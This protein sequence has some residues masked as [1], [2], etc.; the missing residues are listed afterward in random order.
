M[1]NYLFD[2]S[3]EA[4]DKWRIVFWVAL[5]IGSSMAALAIFMWVSERRQSRKSCKAHEP[6]V[7]PTESIPQRSEEVDKSYNQFLA[8]LKRSSGTPLGAPAPSKKKDAPVIT[9]SQA[10][11]ITVKSLDLST[12]EGINAAPSVD[13]IYDGELGFVLLNVAAKDHKK[14]GRYDLATMCYQKMSM[15]L[16]STDSGVRGGLIEAYWSDLYDQRRFDEADLERKKLD[17]YYFRNSKKR[18]DAEY[19][20]VGNNLYT[21]APVRPHCPK[22]FFMDQ[23]WHDLY[24]S[25]YPITT[26]SGKIP[27]ARDYV[28]GDQ[29]Y[30]DFCDRH[31]MVQIIGNEFS[32]NTNDEDDPDAISKK[33]ANLINK[34]V[35]QKEYDWINRNMFELKPQT[36]RKYMS[37]KHKQ[38]EEYIAIRD[39]AESMGFKFYPW[40]DSWY[41]ET[42]DELGLDEFF[43]MDTYYTNP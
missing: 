4:F 15:I 41:Q 7:D 34:R 25:K 12:E 40:V 39:T 11:K 27:S 21:I 32:L 13:F 31:F 5:A 10:E 35:C 33:G 16:F 29:L 38:T 30:C 22:C 17:S 3:P 26:S 23:H 20:K 36:L 37:I 19:A 9:T 14:N 18:A 43:G 6:E 8:D 42:F 24:T 2:M 1:L 28:V